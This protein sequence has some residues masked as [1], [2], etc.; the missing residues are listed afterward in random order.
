[1]FM[2]YR[3]LSACQL[4]KAIDCQPGY[5]LQNNDTI[6]SELQILQNK[7][8][9]VPLGQP[10]RSSSTEA[11]RSLDLKSLSARRF[12]HRCIATTS[13]WLGKLILTLIFSKIKLSIHITQDVPMIF[14]YPFLEL[15]GVNKHLPIKLR[16][17]GTVFQLIWKKH[18]SYLFLNPSWKL[19]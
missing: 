4:N 18:I 19:F 3:R 10:P 12:F 7:D 13:A 16:T 9:K 14:V 5:R 2:Q 17:T 6:M 8:A 1:M 11:L 15:T